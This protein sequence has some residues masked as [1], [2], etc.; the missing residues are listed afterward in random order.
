M[1]F[2]AALYGLLPDVN[3]RVRGVVQRLVQGQSFDE[4]LDADRLIDTA[5]HPGLFLTEVPAVSSWGQGPYYVLL[6]PLFLLRG[7]LT[8]EL[9]PAEMEQIVFERCLETAWGLLL[10]LPHMQSS[11]FHQCQFRW[12]PFLAAAARFYPMLAAEGARFLSAVTPTPLDQTINT[13][14]YVLG[15]M[16]VP[17]PT[18]GTPWPPDWPAQLLAY[19]EVAKQFVH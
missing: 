7:A 11:Y 16:H 5:S 10:L 4:A 1:L 2:P 17:Q 19:S 6:E 8:D 18:P 12:S 3:R 14:H 15:N 13:I 9:V